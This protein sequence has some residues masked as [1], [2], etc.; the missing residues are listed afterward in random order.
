MRDYLLLQ[1]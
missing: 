1:L